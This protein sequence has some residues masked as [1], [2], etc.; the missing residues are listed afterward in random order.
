LEAV[1]PHLERLFEE[2]DFPDLVEG[3]MKHQRLLATSPRPVG[4]E[5]FP[6]IFAA[7]IAY[8]LECGFVPVRKLGKLPGDVIS[9]EYDLEYG[10]NT[11]ELHSDA[12]SPGDRVLIVCH[13]VIVLCLRYLVEDLDEEKVLAIDRAAELANCG[14]T[15][16]ELDA[17]RGALALRRYNFVAPLE[18]Q[19][20]RVTREPDVPVAP[21]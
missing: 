10:T 15:S 18:Q 3:T 21:K 7:P 4:E 17:A 1:R 9:T 12:I 13:Q 8:V 2:G 14:L 19:G 16:Y 20:A 5:D 11:L 6:R